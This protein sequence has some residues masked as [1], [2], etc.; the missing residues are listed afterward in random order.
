MIVEPSENQYIYHLDKY[1]KEIIS[2][3]NKDRMPNKIIFSGKKGLGKSTLAYHIINYILSK[4]EEYSYDQNNL[5]INKDNKSFKLLQNNSHPNFYLIDVLSEK[6]NIDISQIR[7]MINYTNKSSFNNSPRFILIDN[8]EYLNKN[9]VNALL[10][11]VEEPNNNIYFI[12]I[13]NNQKKILPTLKSRCVI[14]N[15]NLSNAKSIDVSNLLLNNN[16]SELIN[17]D[18]INYYNTPGEFIRLINFAN[19]KKINLK[20]HDLISFLKLIIDKSYYKKNKFV[21]NLII[22]YIEL[23]F[24]KIYKFSNS[25]ESLIKT[26]HNFLNRIHTTDRF[27][28]D[29]ESLFFEFRRKLLN[30]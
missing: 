30:E 25:K 2:L 4:D 28:L 27:N 6:K 12:L 23:Y 22:N 10:K 24:L 29:E 15:I 8:I 26:Y 19:E 14:F 21:K 17:V 16:L 9:S 3:F 13:H 7:E 20:D 5:I 11:V 18:L 1:F